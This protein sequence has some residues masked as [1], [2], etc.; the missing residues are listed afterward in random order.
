[1]KWKGRGG[2][3]IEGKLLVV[4]FPVGGFGAELAELTLTGFNVNVLLFR[5]LLPETAAVR[6]ASSANCF[7]HLVM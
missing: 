1:M 5:F 4:P 6:G 3:L 7:F 2:G